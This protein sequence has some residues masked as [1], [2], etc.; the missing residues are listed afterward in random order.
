[1]SENFRPAE[2][3][4]PAPAAPIP[5]VEGLAPRPPMAGP[6]G[7]APRPM[8][9]APGPAAGPRPGGRPRGKY[10][11]RRKVCQFCVDKV[12]H[13]DYK[14]LMRLR[15]FLSDRAKIEPRRKTGTCAKHQRRL[16]M[17][18]KRARHIALLPYTAEHLRQMGG[19]TQPIPG[20]PLPPERPWPPRDSFGPQGST[21]GG[22]RQPAEPRPEAPPAEAQ[23]DEPAAAMPPADPI[24]SGA[25]E[26]VATTASAD[27]EQ[28]AAGPDER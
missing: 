23:V 5:G 19:V 6:G 26:A 13:I 20:Q 28:Q 21:P 17:A 18:L 1:M 27:A 7:F 4:P 25:P 11:P 24:P 3:A 14:D 12:T 16:A 9:A 22:S 15:R 8:G 10:A 2:G